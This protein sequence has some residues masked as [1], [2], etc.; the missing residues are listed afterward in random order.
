LDR[1]PEGLSPATA[2]RIAEHQEGTA[3]GP[4]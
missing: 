1:L 3:P 4:W 2:R